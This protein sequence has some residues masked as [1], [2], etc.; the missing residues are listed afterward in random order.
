MAIVL[1]LLLV[2]GG[3][4]HAQAPRAQFRLED[5]P[6]V[7]VPFHV[8]LLVEGF[9]EAPPPA[10]PPLQIPG[11]TV[12]WIAAQPNVS[13]S[14]QIVNGRRVDA[15]RVTWVMRWRVLATRPGLLKVPSLTVTQGA[16]SA[17]APAGEIQID[18][19]PLADD[20]KLE[21]ELPAR[22]VF[23]GETVPLRL[24]WLFRRQP[25]DPAFTVPLMS[26]DTFT[27]SAP[28]ITN[29]RNVLDFDVGTKTMKLPY[30]IDRHTVNGVEYNRLVVEFFAAPRTAPPGGK[31]EIPPSSVAVKLG[32]GRADF[33]GNAPSKLF[34]ATDVARAMEV[35]LLPVTDRPPSFAGAVGE[36]FAISVATSRSVVQLGEPVELD[37]T[38]KSNQRLDTLAL[39]K[40]DLEGRLPRDKFTVAD[41]PPTGQ[42]S[43][44]GKT[45]TFEVVA[46]VTGPA[47]EIPS[48]VFSYF[49]PKRGAYQTIH[50]EPIALSVK[51]G[52]VVGAGD[53]VS[54]TPGKRAPT[55]LAD[56]T[57]LV[58]AD[59]ALSS[60][61]AVED[62]P[63]G[64]AALWLL[65]GLLYAVPLALLGFRSWRLRT[66]GQREEA[67]EVLTAR[68]RV[69]ELLDR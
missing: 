53:V 66:A 45:K 54:A 27:I 63:L 25:D 41:E 1:L 13:R 57:A 24:V 6:H 42:L 28:P 5:A 32:V 67:S 11:A 9:E 10:P 31:L 3:V 21:L 17:T 23:V 62:R 39:G 43:E 61:G 34:R 38:I 30:V 22:P 20:M 7:D 56:E 37:V 12:S 40:L 47:T 19:V 58:N 36:Q 15:T 49:D 46:Q 69:E 35:K 29:A 26:L 52:S 64:G 48:L 44:D 51:G 55:V 65:I 18:V 8:D 50:S 33:F 60:A 2:L 4:A 16:K 59:L 68:R 14:I